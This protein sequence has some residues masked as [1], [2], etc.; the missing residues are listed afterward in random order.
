MPKTIWKQEFT[1]GVEPQTIQF[2]ANAGFLH[3]A[4][5]DQQ[6]MPSYF[7]DPL[8]TIWFTVDKEDLDRE[9]RTLVVVGTGQDIPVEDEDVLDYIGTI[10]Y[11]GM[12]KHVFE[13]L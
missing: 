5:Q 2:P 9:P 8:P 6:K 7:P 4:M 11:Q 13:V 12:V 10:H 3:V 1:L